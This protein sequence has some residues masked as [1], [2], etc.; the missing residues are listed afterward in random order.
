MGPS[1]LL[2]PSAEGSAG[3]GAGACIRDAIALR[4]V[5]SLLHR[6]AHPMCGLPAC[7]SES[8]TD[9]RVTKSDFGLTP[10]LFS[11]VVE[12]RVQSSFSEGMTTHRLVEKHGT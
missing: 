3:T 7:H 8:A 5:V 4:L 11:F 6:L 9:G 2:H 12:G 10:T 1:S